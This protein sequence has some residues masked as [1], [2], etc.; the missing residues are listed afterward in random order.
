[1]GQLRL[2]RARRHFPPISWFLGNGSVQSIL[3]GVIDTR[4][5]LV[6]MMRTCPIKR[7]CAHIRASKT[8]VSTGWRQQQPRDLATP[9]T[10]QEHSISIGRHRRKVSP[11]VNKCQL[12]PCP[13]SFGGPIFMNLPKILHFP[14][15][16]LLR[17]TFGNR[18]SCAPSRG[19]IRSKFYFGAKKVARGTR[20]TQV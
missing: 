18:A 20:L 12:L 17:S 9:P 19:G 13:R 14:L 6:W 16:A 2:Q 11:L 7:G 8:P 1:M 3:A 10:A 15:T 4:P 5:W